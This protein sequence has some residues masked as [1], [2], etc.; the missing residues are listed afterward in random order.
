[1]LLDVALIIIAIMRGEVYS[2]YNRLTQ[3][4]KSATSAR[5]L[6]SRRAD[7]IC[8]ATTWHQRAR[9]H[10]IRH[11]LYVLIWVSICSIFRDNKP[12]HRVTIFTFQGKVTSSIT[13]HHLIRHM[14][15]PIGGGLLEPSLYL[16]SFSPDSSLP[17]TSKTLMTWADTGLRHI[18]PLSQL[19][20]TIYKIFGPK[21]DI[22]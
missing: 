4:E 5:P 13:W 18:M 8:R 12:K 11:F 22:N 9:D 20:Y 6:A 3:L 1:M 19:T 17:P 10:C 16:Q 7:S 15:F 2:V 14:P 21:H